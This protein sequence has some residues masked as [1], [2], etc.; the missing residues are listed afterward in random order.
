VYVK[1]IIKS[2]YADGARSQK[3]VARGMEVMKLLT[4]QKYQCAAAPVLIR[5]WNGI[6]LRK[7]NLQEC[8]PV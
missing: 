3:F 2:D 5:K 8:S 4:T 1:Y 6:M 7:K